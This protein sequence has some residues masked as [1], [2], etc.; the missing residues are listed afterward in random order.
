MYWTVQNYG[1]IPNPITENNNGFKI[2]IKKCLGIEAFRKFV[3]NR[4]DQYSSSVSK[5][6][7]LQQKDHFIAKD[8]FIYQTF[9]DDL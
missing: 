3:V 9:R 4:I 6:E 7:L 8:Y 5:D 2:K 1:E